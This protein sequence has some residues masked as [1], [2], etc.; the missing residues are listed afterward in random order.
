MS[1]R[2]TALLLCCMVHVGAQARDT[3]T[4]PALVI[5]Q[6]AQSYVVQADGSYVLT[7]DEQRLIALP[8]A[9]QQ[10]GQ[11]QIGYNHAL[12]TIAG[13]VAYTEKPDGRRI[14]VGPEQ[15]RDQQEPASAD[16]PL[17]L[18]SRIKVV[19][20]PDVAVGDR[21]VLHYAVTRS[22][23]L[24]PGHFEDLS[25]AR[26]YLNPAFSL[27]YD[28]PENMPLYA[29]AAGFRQ[30]SIS[31]PPGRKLY[32]WIYQAGE[33][34]RI[35]ADA[36]NYLDYG[37]R[38]A[39]STFA[40]YPAFAQAFR[41]RGAGSQHVTPAVAALA[42][43]LTAGLSE[44]RAKALAL[45]DWVRKNI[46]YVAVYIGPGG[47]APHTAA[48]VLENRYGDCKDQAALLGALLAASGI[49]ST[50]ALVNNANVFRL[51]AVPTL[52]I[53]NHI[54]TY[55]PSLDLYLDPGAAA[56]APAYLP[57]QDLGKP[58]LLLETGVVAGTPSFQ[59]EQNRNKIEFN[60]AKNGSSLFRVIKTNAG[61]LAEPY[62]AAIRAT[63]A[64]ERDQFVPRMLNDA[65]QRGYGLLDAG[66]LD[67]AGDEYQMVFAG[68]SENFA[69]WPGPV[70][71]AT[72]YDFWG[73]IGETIA[74]L[75][76][77][78]R[79]R[80]DFICPAADADDQ[81]DFNFAPGLSILTM[82]KTVSVRGAGFDYRAEYGRKGNTVTVKRHLRFQPAGAVCTADDFKRML[83]LLKRMQADLKSQIVARRR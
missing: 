53:F 15:I 21:L 42:A 3:G 22:N 9:V 8:R 26:F 77:E 46:R 67:G 49:D 63:T 70:A 64:L 82:P 11:R 33:N 30:E 41:E 20:F 39:V 61:A 52:G 83:P 18:D 12:D 74:A 16:A 23:A 34:Q 59:R 48:S 55:I 36:V 19:V 5:E 78:P 44:K 14:A 4:D 57:P 7:V 50:G 71:I 31:S 35:E 62:R 47:V 72:A 65:G 2:L 37:K 29:D 73:G 75:A 13:I 24:F 79:R 76:R 40:G 51:P 60:V 68:V 1:T 66:L 45:A 17:F 58:V 27:T 25:S 38:L 32:R 10:H 28:L 56:Y 80:Q 54:I 69:A 43:T 81:A 6:L